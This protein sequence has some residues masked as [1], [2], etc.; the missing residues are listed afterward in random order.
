MQSLDS[1]IPTGTSILTGGEDGFPV[2][3]FRVVRQLHGLAINLYDDGT[4]DPT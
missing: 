2:G 3:A 1:E 4:R